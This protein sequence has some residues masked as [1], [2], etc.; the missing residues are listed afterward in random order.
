[1][2]EELL[3]RA[4]ERVGCAR[5]TFGW[6]SCMC[7]DCA[8]ETMSHFELV[9]IEC[10]VRTFMAKPEYLELLACRSIAAFFRALAS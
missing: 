10:G 7:P 6:A 1:M 8:E 9:E 4:T 3:I 5:K 2:S